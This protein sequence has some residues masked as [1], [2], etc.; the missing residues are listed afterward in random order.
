VSSAPA[1]GAAAVVAANGSY[2]VFAVNTDNVL[3]QGVFTNGAWSWQ[4]L[5]GAVVGTPGVTYQPG[6][7]DV[8]APGTNGVMY[9]KIYTSGTWG[10]WHSIGRSNFG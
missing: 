9:Q 8:F 2:H 10:G 4:N 3:Y 1:P 6:R 5:G 7:Y